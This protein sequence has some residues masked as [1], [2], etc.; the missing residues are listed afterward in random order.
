MTGT[1]TPLPHLSLSL[2]LHVYSVPASSLQTVRQKTE[3]IESFCLLSFVNES[4]S[5]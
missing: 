5:K 2:A 4:V 3:M 1:P